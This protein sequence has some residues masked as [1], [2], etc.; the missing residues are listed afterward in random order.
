[1]AVTAVNNA[2]FVQISSRRIHK[3]G[4]ISVKI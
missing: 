3:N 4:L 2:V 1:M